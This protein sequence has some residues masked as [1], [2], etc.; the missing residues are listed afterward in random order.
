MVGIIAVQSKMLER[1]D[2]ERLAKHYFIKEVI[3]GWY[4][5]SSPDEQQ[6]DSTAW[7]T[8]FCVAYMEALETASVEQ[9]IAPFTKFLPCYHS[10][11][12]S[13]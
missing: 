8:S 12:P 10:I 7:Y 4:I 2:R 11:Y 6:G 13:L 1:T 5:P 3:R 9:N